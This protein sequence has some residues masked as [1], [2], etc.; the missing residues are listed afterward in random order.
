MFHI[1]VDPFK[2][3][4]IEMWGRISVILLLFK[5]R[6]IIG[7]LVVIINNPLQIYAQGKINQQRAEEVARQE[8]NS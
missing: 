3:G 2:C 4:V 5:V 8:S 6:Y 1:W 7:Y